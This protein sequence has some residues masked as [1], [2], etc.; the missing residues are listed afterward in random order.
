M[1]E[2]LENCFLVKQG[3]GLKRLGLTQVLHFEAEE[4][5]WGGA[6]RKSCFDDLR[7]PVDLDGIKRSLIHG[8]AEY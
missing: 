6:A 5:G 7:S 1:Q 2:V 3:P 4:A 8:V